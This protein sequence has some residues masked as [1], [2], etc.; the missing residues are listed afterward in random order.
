LQLQVLLPQQLPSVLLA[1]LLW[2]QLLMGWHQQ[3]QQQGL[4]HLL[5]RQ[6][7]PKVCQSARLRW[8]CSSNSWQLLRPAVHSLHWMKQ[9]RQPWLRRQQL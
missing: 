3:Q 6:V 7:L 1:L 9:G 8:R 5:L 4:L 2:G